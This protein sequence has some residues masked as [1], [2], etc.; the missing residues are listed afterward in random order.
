M[1]N[2]C[3]TGTVSPVLEARCWRPLVFLVK[4]TGSTS[5]FTHWVCIELW[6]DTMI[7]TFDCI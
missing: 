7:V 1:E 5:V 2:N 4:T 6:T 3:G